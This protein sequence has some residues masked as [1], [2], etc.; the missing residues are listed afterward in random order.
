MP[1][2]IAAFADTH[3]EMGKKFGFGTMLEEFRKTLLRELD[4]QNQSKDG[5]PMPADVRAN[6]PKT[7]A[8]LEQL[9][10]AHNAG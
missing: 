2:E 1:I 8:M 4:Y 9:R 3:T 7:A 5:A 10:A 6:V